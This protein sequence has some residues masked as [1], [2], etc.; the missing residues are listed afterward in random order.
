MNK[1]TAKKSGNTS[2][3]KFPV[4]ATIEVKQN[5]KITIPSKKA[6]AAEDVEREV[7]AWRIEALEEEVLQLSTA[8]YTHKHAV[9]ELKQKEKD[10]HEFAKGLLW[11]LIA[12]EII[13][14][15]AYFLG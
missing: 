11:M 12:W 9:D 13:T 6:I 15:M 7:L 14:I 8:V 3:T 5:P 4:K 2:K 10:S 1:I